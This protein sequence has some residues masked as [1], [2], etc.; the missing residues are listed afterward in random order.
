MDVVR[1]QWSNLSSVSA[2]STTNPIRI[3]AGAKTLPRASQT[4]PSRRQ[5]PPRIGL[6]GNVYIGLESIHLTDL[7]IEKIQIPIPDSMI[8][9]SEIPK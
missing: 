1:L 7:P 9:R 6:Q 3:S 2:S 8:P 4:I 5:E